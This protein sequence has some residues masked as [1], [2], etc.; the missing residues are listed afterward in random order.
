MNNRRA[1]KCVLAM[2]VAAGAFATVAAAQQQVPPLKVTRIRDNVWVTQGGD[3]GNTGIIVGTTGV[4]VVDTKTTVASSKDVQAEIAKITT[5]PVTTAILTHSDGDHANGVAGFPPGL[6]IIAQENAKKEMIASA[7]TRGAYPQD[8]LPTKTIGKDETMTIDGVRVR[9]L[10]WAPG[11]TSGDL[12]VFFPDEKVVFMGDLMTYP[13]RP[14]VLAITGGTLIHTEKNGSAAGLLVNLKG[15]VGLNADTFVTGH[16]ELMTK[17]DAKERY[18]FIQ[19]KWNKVK[20]MSAQGKSEEEIKAAVGERT[21]ARGTPGLPVGVPAK[22][23]SEV[24][25]DEINSKKKS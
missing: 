17:Q 20:A 1:L 24:M 23:L 10:H 21:V 9:M 22:T 11:H 6:Q 13:N 25:Y 7:G 19:D 8:R 3:G 5:K 14:D 12:I 16:G 18:A 2:S 15:V 4:I